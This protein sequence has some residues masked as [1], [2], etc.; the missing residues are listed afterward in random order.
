MRMTL[1]RSELVAII[2]KNFGYE[3]NEEDVVVQAEPF[4]VHIKNIDLS[5]LAAKRATQPDEVSPDVEEVPPEAGET[6]L[7]DERIEEEGDESVDSLLTLN[8]ILQQNENMGG[9]PLS[10]PLGPLESEE[11]PEITD[12]ELAATKRTGG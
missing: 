7:D 10:R 2:G 8:D 4:E 1:E 9:P 6:E 11:P 5:K 12:A 3:L